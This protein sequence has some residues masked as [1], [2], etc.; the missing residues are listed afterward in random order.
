[1]P[2]HQHELCSMLIYTRLNQLLCQGSLSE[3]ARHFFICPMSA[4]E[5]CASMLLGNTLHYPKSNITGS[6][7]TVPSQNCNSKPRNGSAK[8]KLRA[9]SPRGPQQY[10]RTTQDSRQG[11]G[12]AQKWLISCISDPFLTFPSQPRHGKN[13]SVMLAVGLSLRWESNIVEPCHRRAICEGQTKMTA[14]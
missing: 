6:P 4:R 7:K 3:V 8:S 14:L 13:N 1:M 9:C 5:R 11:K 12:N 2:Y 10:A